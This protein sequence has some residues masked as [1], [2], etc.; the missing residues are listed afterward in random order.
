M[1]SHGCSRMCSLLPI[2]TPAA[3]TTPFAPFLWCGEAR[4]RGGCG[5]VQAAGRG[6]CRLQDLSRQSMNNSGTTPFA[7]FLV[8]FLD[9]RL[10]GAENSN[11]HGARPVHKIVSMTKWMRTSRLSIQN[12]LPETWMRGGCCFERARRFIPS[13]PQH[14]LRPLNLP[15]RANHC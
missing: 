2:R 1:Q 4:V 8:C 11:S 15:Q 10:L 13:G 7:P 12:S 3:C 9:I 6:A 5:V 14:F